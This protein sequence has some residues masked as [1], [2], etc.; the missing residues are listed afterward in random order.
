MKNQS[1]PPLIL[2][3]GM[4]HERPEHIIFK[5]TPAKEKSIEFNAINF[6]LRL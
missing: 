4:R 1:N 6:V 5:P 3:K 2:L